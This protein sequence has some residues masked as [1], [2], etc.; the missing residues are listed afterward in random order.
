[1]SESSLLFT[2]GFSLANLLGHYG[3]EGSTAL[4]CRLMVV[5]HV[6]HARH[7]SLSICMRRPF[8]CFTPM[9][10]LHYS[11]LIRGAK[12]PD[13]SG[14]PDIIRLFRLTHSMW[15]KFPRLFF[16]W[17][18]CTSALLVITPCVEWGLTL[19]TSKKSN[20]IK[21]PGHSFFRSF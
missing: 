8:C 5:W 3:H 9:D 14:N 19:I 4:I 18:V 11:G 21:H 17:P 6:W 12:F 13:K 15:F 20:V 7:K 1:M 2:G 16:S 10:R